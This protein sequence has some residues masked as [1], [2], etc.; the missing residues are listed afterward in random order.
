MI[1]PHSEPVRW[2]PVAQFLRRRAIP[3]A[4]TAGTPDWCAL[5]DDDPRK[6]AALAV[7]GSRWVLEQQLAQ[8]RMAEDA[9]YDQWWR[10]ELDRLDLP[11]I[12]PAEAVRIVS[13]KD[14]TVWLSQHLCVH[15]DGFA[16]LQTLPDTPNRKAA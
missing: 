9:A 3:V 12:D 5:E 15:R 7:A 1:E 14:A 6:W 4:P 10:D 2:D 16:H 11:H 8:R 13:L